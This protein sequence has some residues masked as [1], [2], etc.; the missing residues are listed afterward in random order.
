MA[1]DV[2][3]ALYKKTKEPFRLAEAISWLELVIEQDVLY[4]LY[5]GEDGTETQEHKQLY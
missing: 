4:C 2:P 5:W 1:I 3:L